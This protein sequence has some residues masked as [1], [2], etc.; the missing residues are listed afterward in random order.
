M[1]GF[2]TPITT[3]V[4]NRLEK[5]KLPIQITTDS[6]IFVLIQLILSSWKGFHG[7]QYLGLL[8]LTRTKPEDLNSV[9]LYYV[10]IMQDTSFVCKTQ[11]SCGLNDEL[12][13]QNLTLF[14]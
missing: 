2:Q 5:E 10:Y 11:Q 3:T 14:N 9:N 6:N 12:N 8:A 4:T 13:E 1:G 7:R